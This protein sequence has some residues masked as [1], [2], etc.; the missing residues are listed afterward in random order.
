MGMKRQQK[1][2]SSVQDMF[3]RPQCNRNSATLSVLFQMH[4][5]SVNA[6]SHHTCF[7]AAVVLNTAYQNG[8]INGVKCNGFLSTP[9]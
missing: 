1:L 3:F 9:M 4:I 5:P 8:R 2:K 7:V 6:F